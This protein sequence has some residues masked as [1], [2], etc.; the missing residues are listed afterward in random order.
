MTMLGLRRVR[1]GY[2]NDQA[3]ELSARGGR[4]TV[5]L[6]EGGAGTGGSTALGREFVAS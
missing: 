5:G 1:L 2:W 6:N 3:A 4:Y